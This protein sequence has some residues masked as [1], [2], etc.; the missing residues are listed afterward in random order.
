MIREEEGRII[1]EKQ[2]NKID[3]TFL[4]NNEVEEKRAM[5]ETRW[6]RIS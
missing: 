3:L 5:I 6:T 2:K 1:L 4:L